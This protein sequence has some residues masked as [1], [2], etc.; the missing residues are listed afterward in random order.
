MLW[1]KRNEVIKMKKNK[2]SIVALIIS[3]LPF[4]T[5]L[6]S[7]FT[8]EIT[9]GLQMGLIALNIISILC[10]F[11]ISISLIKTQNVEIYFLL[12]LYVSAPF[13]L[14]SWSVFL[15]LVLFTLL[16]KLYL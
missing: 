10:G 4:I 3:L 2:L 7:L 16:C 15:P 1:K 13:L 5:L 11:G 14:C 6:I 9:G 8:E 12:L